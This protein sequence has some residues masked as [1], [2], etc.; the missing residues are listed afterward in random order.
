[1]GAPHVSAS[2]RSVPLA[3]ACG[4]RGSNA[5]RCACGAWKRVLLSP[6]GTSRCDFSSSQAQGRRGFSYAPVSGPAEAVRVRIMWRPR[7]MGPGAADAAGRPGRRLCL[8][9]GR[10]SSAAPP[11]EFRAVLGM[12]SA[13]PGLGSLPRRRGQSL[14]SGGPVGILYRLFTGSP[15]STSLERKRAVTPAPSPLPGTPPENRTVPVPVPSGRRGGE[16]TGRGAYR[17]GKLWN[18]S[19]CVSGRGREPA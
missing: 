13:L 12:T 7:E 19:S 2:L 6:L 8:R 1:M 4:G 16:Y 3:P 5:E 14:H 18:S 15:G 17:I 10:H 11:P 9:V